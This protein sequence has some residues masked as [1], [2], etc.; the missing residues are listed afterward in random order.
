MTKESGDSPRR[1]PKSCSTPAVD[2]HFLR[3]R[4]PG[5]GR[6][7]PICGIGRRQPKAAGAR[8]GRARADLT[9]VASATIEKAILEQECPGI[10]VRILS[11]DLPERGYCD[12]GVRRSAVISSLLTRLPPP[13]QRRRR[14]LLRTRDV[15]RVRERLPDAVFQV[16][17]P[18]AAAGC[19]GGRLREHPRRRLRAGSQ[20]VL[21]SCPDLGSTHSVRGGSERQSE[22]EH[23][24][25]SAHGPHLN[26]GRGDVPGPRGECHDRR[27]RRELRRR[28]WN[29]HLDFLA[30][31][32]TQCRPTA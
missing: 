27:R 30:S 32:P 28:V 15:P 29:S 31:F 6:A 20:T 22:P 21:R 10:D 3:R 16:I 7:R 13:T 24:A 11:S 14:P 18:D 25:R 5:S 2:L 12:S 19:S 26:G 9:L 4:T 23:G 8:T 1:T 17:G